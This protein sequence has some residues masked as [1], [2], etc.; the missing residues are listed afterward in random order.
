VA[1]GICKNFESREC[2]DANPI[3]DV[4]VGVCSLNSL[5][6]FENLITR[7]FSLHQWPC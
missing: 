2:V 5:L 7:R 3:G 1:D 6:S 4:D